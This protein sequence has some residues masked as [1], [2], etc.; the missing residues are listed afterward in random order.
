[1]FSDYH[2]Q[3]MS[4]GEGSSLAMASSAKATML[5]CAIAE[6]S[7]QGAAALTLSEISENKGSEDG[8]DV[9]DNKES[10]D[11]SDVIDKESE[12]RSDVIDKVKEVVYFHS[13][14]IVVEEYLMGHFM[15]G[16][17]GH[18][19]SPLQLIEKKHGVII[20]VRK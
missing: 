13:E 3:E 5:D 16:Y 11:D 14:Y 20:Q 10:E 17:K 7:L 1:M 18:E 12:D 15:R 4:G 8:S 19:M 6:L 2:L 9:I